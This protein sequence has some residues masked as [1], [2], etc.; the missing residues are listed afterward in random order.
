[1]VITLGDA[2]YRFEYFPTNPWV[3]FVWFKFQRSSKLF[4]KKTK[5]TEKHEKLMHKRHEIIQRQIKKIYV[6]R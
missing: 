1:M 5:K 6:C 4:W 3:D 2:I